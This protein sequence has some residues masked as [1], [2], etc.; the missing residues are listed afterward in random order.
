MRAARGRQLASGRFAALSPE[1]ASGSDGFRSVLEVAPEDE[2]RC[3]L[4]LGSRRDGQSRVALEHLDPTREIRGRVLQGPG[5]D[6]GG[7]AEKGG[8][9]LR[10]ELLAAVVVRSEH[11]RARDP[12]AAKPRLVAGAVRELVKERRVVER[13]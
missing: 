4:R 1:P 13:G 3:L 7:A 12:L 10:N 5:L 9:H 6:S 2:V 11:A 8:T